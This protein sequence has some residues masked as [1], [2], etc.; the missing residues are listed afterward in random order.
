MN[1]NPYE[2]HNIAELDSASGYPGSLLR[3]IPKAV[4]ES[5]EN[6]ALAAEETSLS[7]LR[8]VVESG[9]RLSFSLTA[10]N[11]GDLFIYRGD[12][13]QNHVRLPANGVY[14]HILDFENDCFAKMRPEAT[15]RNRNSFSPK[16]WRVVL[17]SNSDA[18]VQ[19]GDHSEIKM[20]V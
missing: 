7:E 19:S 16:V 18:I 8:F 20:S 11:G 1:T 10:L 9:Q 6:G 5:L 3:R 12:F 17:I 14:R 15:A 4:A 13:V 2:L